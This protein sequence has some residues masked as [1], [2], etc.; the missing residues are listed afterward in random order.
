MKKVLLLFAFCLS[1]STLLGQ[2]VL[3]NNLW[4][5]DGEI[6]DSE[7][8]GNNI[9]VVGKF[10]KVLP[11]TGKASI[12]SIQTGDVNITNNI[13]TDGEIKTITPDGNGGYYLGGNFREV[14]G[15]PRTNI[16]HIDAQ[17]NLT[18]FNP[19]IQGTVNE[20]FFDNGKLIIRGN[21]WRINNLDLQ[22]FAVYYTASG[23]FTSSFINDSEINLSISEGERFRLYNG[24]LYYISKVNNQSK[25]CRFQIYSAFPSVEQLNFVGNS[26]VSEMLFRNDTAFIFGNFVQIG[27]ALRNRTAAINLNSFSVLP[28]YP[29]ANGTVST[30]ALDGNKLFLGGSFTS[31]GGRPCDGI[32]VIDVATALANEW[33][34]SFDNINEIDNRR[35]GGIINKLFTDNGKL[36]V[37]GIF[38]NIGTEY[39]SYFARFNTNDLSLDNWF[40]VADGSV[41][42]I[43]KMGNNLFTAGDFNKIGGKLRTNFAC[44]NLETGVVQPIVAELNNVANDI[45]NVDNDQI[46]ICG[47]FTSV[48]GIS[49]NKVA[50]INLDNGQ[51]GSFNPSVNFPSWPV[52]RIES[53]T[54]LYVFYD[55]GITVLDKNSGTAIGWR[56]NPSGYIFAAKELNGKLYVGGSF[57]GIDNQPVSHLAALDVN[58]RQ[59]LNWNVQP[60]DQ[61][62]DIEVYNGKL[63]VAGEFFNIG[64]RPR[65]YFAELDPNSEIATNTVANADAPITDIAL[66]N[67]LLYLFGGFNIFADTRF[68]TNLAP[69]DLVNKQVGVWR[70]P[71]GFNGSYNIS[72]ARNVV[73][74]TKRTWQDWNQQ[75][76]YLQVFR[77][78]PDLALN[79]KSDIVTNGIALFPNP[80]KDKVALQLPADKVGSA[81]TI[82][83]FSMN[84]ALMQSN[85][86]NATESEISL[87][88][89]KAGL[90]L[91]KV[92]LDN[93]TQYSG[94]VVKE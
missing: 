19:N 88:E 74:V 29:N 60:N 58:S 13:R 45:L 93:G 53:G 7:I 73:T 63:L 21:Y 82:N 50:K 76:R 15:N 94:K 85:A 64:L 90:Y 71:V 4:D 8:I 1:V 92:I 42:I 68:A 51:L 59:T 80:A 37:G 10:R 11:I 14:N 49:R 32:A 46:F 89:L 43:E 38:T 70:S 25:L 67:N 77:N 24:R 61:V 69:F 52:D 72:S 84:G 27:S 20:L 55:R 22:N 62:N 79:T 44:L 66:N 30:A 81:G 23:E 36:Y 78:D 34:P 86:F 12:I 26:S 65:N 57:S 87:A 16:C 18:S 17:R 28:W 9:Y 31:I 91:Y 48:N 6:Y 47:Q 3:M 5:T 56:I 54:Y 2:T 83:L 35:S 33:N 40:S 39:R 75:G 41:K